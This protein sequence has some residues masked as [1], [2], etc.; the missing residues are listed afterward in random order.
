MFS[1]S[2]FQI[3]YCCNSG[4]KISRFNELES[5]GNIKGHIALIHLLRF[6]NLL[7]HTVARLSTVGQK[8]PHLVAVR[9]ELQAVIYADFPLLGVCIVQ[10]LRE[11]K[12]RSYRHIPAFNRGAAK[13]RGIFNILLIVPAE[14]GANINLFHVYLLALQLSPVRAIA[15]HISVRRS[16]VAC[17]VI[18]SFVSRG[19]IRAL[20][21]AAG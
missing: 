1:S 9:E 16:S 11:I 18:W 6:L 5:L 17:A 20:S 14:R 21:S 13:F 8:Y 19:V 3:V 12:V 7:A 10:K 2:L 4:D 15:R